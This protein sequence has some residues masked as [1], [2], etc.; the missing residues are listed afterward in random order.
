M[1]DQPAKRVPPHDLDAETGL[2]GAA[3]LYADAA[4]VVTT[5]DPAD[6]YR[7]AHGNI[8][9][10]IAAIVGR[11][12][13]VD[14][15]TVA[16]Q[17]ATVGLLD[18]S[19]GGGALVELTGHAALPSA[20]DTYASIIARHAA[21]RRIMRIA[22]EL[23]EH[24]YS[25]TADPG[26]LLQ[27]ARDRLD[28]LPADAGSTLAWADIPAIIAGG[29]APTVDADYLTRTDGQALLYA[30]KLHFLWG[31]PSA[32]KGWIALT[33][34][35]QVLEADGTVVYLDLEDT[36]AGIVSRLLA[37]QVRPEQLGRFHLVRP[38][39]PLGPAELGDLEQRARAANPDLLV[40]DGLAEALMND[41]A[42]ENDN[43]EVTRWLRT[44][45]RRLAEATGAAVLMIDHVAKAKDDRGGWGRGAGAKKAAIDG[46]AYI[47]EVREAFSRHVPGRIDL[48]VSKDRQGAVGPTGAVAAHFHIEPAGGGS[49]VTTR[50]EPPSADEAEGKPTDAMT[51][52]SAAI[53]SNE[54]QSGAQLS[55][56]V[57]YRPAV[58][59]QALR[60][61]ELGGY[62][63]GEKKGNGR[64][65]W[66]RRPYP[67]PDPPVDRD[68]RHLHVV[69]PGDPMF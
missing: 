27:Q 38:R 26:D 7:P 4:T 57:R 17:L 60:A 1:T 49:V 8:A 68:G 22:G 53:A 59:S 6:F 62:V 46:A 34:C 48:I 29:V 45:P 32:G 67:D 2:L 69:R 16:D 12:D 55:K 44:R 51:A 52:L 36:D 54:G 58:V 42:D 64:I 21:T 63:L 23:L 43:I 15:I 30:G 19:G 50:V 25:G 66:H 37:L 39:G 40:I 11:S 10:A 56:L 31:E 41:E 61:L 13:P 18:Q 47:V 65:W 28:T 33:A 35:R 3:L 24:G 9:A 20:V 14:A 5:I